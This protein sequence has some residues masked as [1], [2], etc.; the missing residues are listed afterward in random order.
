MI[1]ILQI[2][3]SLGVGAFLAIVIFLLAMRYISHVTSQ[4]REDRKFMED[5]LT[6][7][8]KENFDIRQMYIKKA[9]ELTKALSELTTF[10]VRQNGKK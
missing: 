5:R 4:V 2:A 8:I 6:G 3:A 7:L 10:L 9:E 1:E